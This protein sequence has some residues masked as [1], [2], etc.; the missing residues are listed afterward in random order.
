MSSTTALELRHISKVFGATRALSDVDLTVEQGEVLAL[1]GENGCG[2]STLVKVLA[3]VN[4][5][6]PGGWLAV[7]GREVTLPMALGAS[8]G[9]GLSFVHQDLGL[10]K[11]LTVVENLL[12][13]SLATGGPSRRRI[14]WRREIRAAAKMLGSYG[15]NID[16][17]LVVNDL[18]PVD[19]ALV[20]IAR[21][22]DQLEQYRA[23]TGAA[24]S[25]LVLDEPTVFLPEHEVEFLFDLI[26]RVVASGSSV[27]FISH[28]LAAVREIAD[29][30]TILRDG[31]V[32]AT[33]AMSDVSDDEIVE[34]IVGSAAAAAAAGGP[35]GAA[36]RL[37]QFDSGSPAAV[38]VTGLRGG[39]VHDLDL[40]VASG[41]V[42][43]LAG[44]MGSGVED[45]P[46]LLFGA[47]PAGGT[48]ALRDASVD[49]TRHSPAAAVRMGMALIPADRRRDAI[50]PAVSVAENMMLPVAQRFSRAGWLRVGEL[51]AT[52]D[53]RA[54]RLDVRPRRTSLPIG[55]LSGGNAQ[56]VVLAK[57]LEIEP[58]L[59]VLHEPTQGVDVAARAEIYRVI[60]RATTTGM[61]VIWVSSDF[62]ELAT[63]CH[64]VVVVSD[65]RQAGQ[66]E[67]AVMSPEA[68]ST[69]VYAAARATT[70]SSLSTT[71]K[72]H[73]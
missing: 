14:N 25:V 72:V 59:L 29:R 11:P 2:K 53:E 21:A 48:L 15:V 67:G 51:R 8:S 23:R 41:E 40:T 54:E 46:Y 28:D 36:Q 49:L 16:P 13:S 31:R 66:V 45:V 62:D 37:R 61:S 27:V 38:T 73:Q 18:P 65:G 44:L 17:R 1:L 30:V 63:V 69:A 19:Q 26:R 52:A 10:A 7:D 71:E 35:V 9:L 20:A 3:G 70:E 43:G 33:A 50:A 55:T 68:I 5:P 12:G 64:R 4:V 57:W 56:K 32:A 39:R 60:E 22:A 24:S 42:V 6:E 58:R 34:L 47:R